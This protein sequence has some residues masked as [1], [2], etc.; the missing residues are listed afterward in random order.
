VYEILPV[1]VPAPVVP[2][3]RIHPSLLRAVHA[4][5]V[6]EAFTSTVLDPAPGPTRAVVGD[7]VTVHAAPAACV[8][9]QYR[10]ARAASDYLNSVTY[11]QG[12]YISFSNSV[13][14]ATADLG[15]NSVPQNLSNCV[16]T[17]TIG[18]STVSNMATG[19]IVNATGGVWGA[20]VIIPAADPC[21][22]E[23]GV[24]NVFNYTYPREKVRTRA[25]LP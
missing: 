8:M 7:S 11:Y 18:N 12:D 10:D 5:V 14:Y 21:Y 20:E 13:M 17:V 22:I 2:L 24:S 3:I 1:P 25:K 6:V 16:I 19:Y 9:S 15:T 23:V 4:H